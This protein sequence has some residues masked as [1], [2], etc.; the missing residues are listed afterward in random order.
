MYCS[1][2][3]YNTLGIPS[4]SSTILDLLFLDT[5][6]CTRH[7]YLILHKANYA[8]LNRSSLA[9][10]VWC[11]VLCSMNLSIKPSTS[12]SPSST[13]ADATSSDSLYACFLAAVS[14]RI[15]SRRSGGAQ[16]FVCLASSA[17]NASVFSLKS[18]CSVATSACTIVNSSSRFKLAS[19]VSTLPFCMEDCKS[20]SVVTADICSTKDLNFSSLSNK[21]CISSFDMLSSSGNDAGT[22]GIG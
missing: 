21:S 15:T 10:R 6:E 22:A 8:A 12:Q 7:A 5:Y 18:L 16:S 17:R 19:A 9:A 4:R 11:T 3:Y 1:P 13:Q 2:A 14:L 20:M